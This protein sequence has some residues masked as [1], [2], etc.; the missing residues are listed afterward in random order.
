MR[1]MDLDLAEAEVG[2]RRGAELGRLG[3]GRKEPWL[4]GVGALGA[5]GMEAGLMAAMGG[6]CFMWKKLTHCCSVVYEKDKGEGWF[7]RLGVGV[8]KM[9]PSK[10]G[11][12]LF[13][14]N[15]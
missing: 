12:L 14:E 15:C 5:P 4:D 13:I 11:A 10:K 9:L 6:S 2:P 7:R 3:A 8:Q 1:A